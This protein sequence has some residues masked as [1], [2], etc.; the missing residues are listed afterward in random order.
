[1]MTSAKTTQASPELLANFIPFSECSQDELIVLADHS[2]G[3]PGSIRDRG[4]PYLHNPGSS[5]ACYRVSSPG[6]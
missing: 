1:M 4:I 5:A 6:W 2:W 3:L